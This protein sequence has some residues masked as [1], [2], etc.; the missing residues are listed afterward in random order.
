M[1]DAGALVREAMALANAGEDQAAQQRFSEAL[2]RFPNDARVANSAGNFHARARRNEAAL[3]HFLRALELEPDFA[4]AAANAGIVYLRLN[5]PE[6]LLQLFASHLDPARYTAQLWALRADA[7][8]L[9]NQL[10]CAS[11]SY[12][13]ALGKDPANK[14]AL[15]GRAR[16]SLERGEVRAVADFQ[17]VLAQSP[18][19]PET[20]CDYIEALLGNDLLDDAR[21]A[22]AV[23]I[24]QLP[25]WARGQ[26]Q[27]AE[28]EWAVGD[29]EGF[30]RELARAAETVSSPELYMAWGSLL[31]GAGQ[32]QR[33]AEILDKAL[34]KWPDRPDLALNCAIC[35]DEAG[36]TQRAGALFKT[37]DASASLDWSIA[38]A[39]H[40]IQ[41]GAFDEAERLLGGIIKADHPSSEAWA[42]IDICWRTMDDPRHAWLHGQE[43]L[44]QS[45]SLNL[46]AAELN[47]IT[48][49]LLRLHQRSFEPFGQSIKGGSQTKGALLH[50]L[51]PELQVLKNALTDALQAYRA[52]LPPR[53]D[54]H[55]LLSKRGSTWEISGSWSILMN[56]SGQHVSHVHPQGVLSSAC[57]IVLPNNIGEPGQGG[58]LEL[59]RPPALLAPQL[60]PLATI[61]PTVG[62]CVLFPSTLFHGTQPLSGG[63]RMSVAFD[64]KA[65]S[66]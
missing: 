28:L 62:H 40:L 18:G 45:V 59:G 11:A 19:D 41:L 49:V 2:A 54:G 44:V 21:Q 65:V 9:S 56:G 38:Y 13:E 48:E 60:E 39:R 15:A 23:L 43:G 42:L 14:R 35:L 25:G 26:V 6:N 32:Q 33:A 63:R 34:A 53:D 61:R 22:A 17:Q 46:S 24:S 58:L 52:A 51:E 66:G 30:D 16:L 1:T 20:F 12:A 5:R 27:F 10:N 55:P 4:E 57:Y 8:R 31:A 36:D 7:E 64:V 50:R 29:R 3:A 47:G 37:F